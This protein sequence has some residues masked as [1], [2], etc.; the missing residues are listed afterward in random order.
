MTTPTAPLRCHLL[1]GQPASGKTTLAGLLAPMLRSPGGV[2]ALVLSTDRLRQ[3]A[4]GDAAVQGPWGDI[5]ALLEQR[6]LEAVAAGRPVIVDATHARR[7]WRLALTQALALPRPVEWIGWW[8]HT[9]LEASLRWNLQR[10]RRVPEAV[11]REMAAALANPHFGPCRAEGFATICS[12][13][14]SFSDDPNQLVPLLEREL[15]ALD[16]RIRAA[17]NRERKLQRHGYSNLLD[18]ERLLYL[19]RLLATYPDLEGRD[20]GTR[21]ALAA[22]VS[23]PPEGPLAQ[24]AAVYLARLH[25]ACYGDAD[26]I[27]ADLLWLEA[28][29]FSSAVA[30]L[31]P[32]QLAKA[33]TPTGRH[34]PA[35]TSPEPR[36]P[37][38]GGLHGG[39]PPMGDGP[40]FQRVMTLLRHLLRQ[41]FDHPSASGAHLGSSGAPPSSGGASL[42]RHLIEATSAIPGGYL[43]GEIDTLRKDL[44]KVLTP[45][46]FRSRNDN[47]RHGYSLGTAVL[48]APRLREV[49]AVVSQAAGRLGDP[50][51]QD[52]VE[53][54]QQRLGWAGL[55]GGEGPPV[56]SYARHT[57]LET[58]LERR[59]SLAAPR[60]AERIEA[61]IF[62]R[63]RVLLRRF[64][65]VG[66]HDGQ[67]GD[68]LAGERQG[69]LRRERQGELRG[70][71]LQLVF[72]AVGWYLMLEDDAIG[73]EEGLIFCERLDRLQLVRAEPLLARSP[74]RHQR[75]VRRLERLLHHCGGLYFGE[76]LEAQLALTSTNP[77]QRASQLRTLRFSCAPWAFAFLREGLGRYPLE[78]TRLSRPLPGESWWHHPRAPHV[79][80]PNPCHD[81][82]PYPVELDLPPWTLAHDVDLRRW[83]FGFGAGIRIEQPLA[84]RQ[85]LLQR[86]HDV[87]AL[88]GQPPAELGER[89]GAGGEMAAG[90]GPRAGGG[91]GPRME[92]A[93]AADAEIPPEADAEVLPEAVGRDA[94]GTQDSAAAA[95]DAAPSQPT[96]PFFPNRWRR[97]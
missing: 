82:H 22:F 39:L 47:V 46:G 50:S 7:P 74:D 9:P 23:P 4:F 67:L 95:A 19:I 83:L 17:T 88:H 60:Q 71:P 97:G 21:E 25:G 10:E 73:H 78:Q 72:H 20:P 62:A 66:S 69:E 56:R 8:L 65:A 49:Y 96:P 38:R 5:Q 84:L 1:I 32:I 79:L 2:E 33:P 63:Q 18:L 54:L 80:E 92:S 27:A 26:A 30:A 52:L 90:A 91:A 16:T 3:E 15:S 59:E 24:R 51:A 37:A 85:E 89:A 86:C 41:P 75:A 81:S 68:D 11:I 29:G 13:V 93:I 87:L 34:T 76:D 94:P 44:E 48:S 70:W 43:P 53:E 36:P 57:I 77:R 45:Y 64:E 6:L 58:G 31:G 61:A 35:H 28:N 55:A 14:P 42:H 12:L 40:V